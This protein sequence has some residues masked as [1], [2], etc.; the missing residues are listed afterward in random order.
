[1]RVACICN[2][3][4]PEFDLVP[5]QR[6]VAGEQ[7]QEIAS[8]PVNSRVTNVCQSNAVIVKQRQRQGGSHAMVRRPPTRR[9]EYCLVGSNNAVFNCPQRRKLGRVRSELANAGLEAAHDYLCSHLACD[10]AG[11]VSAATPDSGSVTM[12]SSLNWRTLP[13]SVTAAISMKSGDMHHM[14][15]GLESSHKPCCSNS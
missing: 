2:G 1:M 14:L 7:L 12:L 15:T 4:E 3:D 5:E 11:M 9:I 13:A 6:I 10:L 8:E